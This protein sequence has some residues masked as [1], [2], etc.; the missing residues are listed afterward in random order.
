[1]NIS[2]TSSGQRRSDRDPA[3]CAYCDHHADGHDYADV[4][5]RPHVPCVNCPGGICDRKHARERRAVDKF[6]EE[7]AAWWATDPGTWADDAL[8]YDGSGGYWHGRCARQAWLPEQLAVAEVS[9]IIRDGDAHGF[10]CGGCL[11]LL[12]D[13]DV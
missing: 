1:M 2:T 4:S 12:G 13:E 7:A 6:H 3:Y 10:A 5:R 8:V 9:A 11:D